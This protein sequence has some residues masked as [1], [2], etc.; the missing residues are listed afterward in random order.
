MKFTQEQMTRAAEKWAAIY[1]AVKEIESSDGEISTAMSL[2]KHA[3]PTI[4]RDQTVIQLMV[5]ERNGYIEGVRGADGKAMMPMA[6]KITEK[7]HEYFKRM[8]EE[9]KE[10]ASELGEGAV[11]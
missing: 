3:Y 2:F 9:T 11:G 10:L 5:M 1:E 6:V 8:I 4:T 7:G